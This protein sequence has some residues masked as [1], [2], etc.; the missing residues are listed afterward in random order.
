MSMATTVWHDEARGDFPVEVLWPTGGGA[1]GV[2]LFSHGAFSAPEK[3]RALTGLWAA[4]GYVVVAPVHADSESWIGTKPSQSQQ[5]QWRLS[6]LE[7][8]PQRI[9]ALSRIIGT[10][11]L[12]GMPRITAGHSLGALLAQMLA[13]PDSAKAQDHRPVGVIAFSPPPP[14][15]GVISAEGWASVTAPQLV[16][17]GTADILPP[18]VTDWRLHLASFEAARAPTYA[19]VAPDGDH[20]FGNIIG[21]TEYSAE[22]QKAGFDRAVM[23]SLLFLDAYAEGDD[24]AL[25]QLSNAGDVTGRNLE[26]NQR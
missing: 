9:G 21:R 20:Y 23:V 8:T 26:K 24:K 12:G 5:I 17:T 6:D 2:I 22:P 19:Y 25:T 1:K 15:P 3:Y 18:F 7:L 14:I 4:A 13:Q 16:V 11:S 10:D